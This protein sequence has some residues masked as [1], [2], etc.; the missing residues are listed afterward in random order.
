VL[1]RILQG[2]ALIYSQG[3]PAGFS[4]PLP[5]RV[6]YQDGAAVLFCCVHAASRDIEGLSSLE[7]GRRLHHCWLVIARHIRCRDVLRRMGTCPAST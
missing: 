5:L 6:S 7:Y 3:T 2:F 1:M 4:S